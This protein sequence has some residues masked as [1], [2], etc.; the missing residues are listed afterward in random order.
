MKT[1]IYYFLNAEETKSYQ[2][3]SK[4]FVI[5]ICLGDLKNW[6]HFCGQRAHTV[7]IDKEF[8]TKT[9]QDIIK[10]VI[11]PLACLNGGEGICF[12]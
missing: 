7:Y 4:N 3:N 1:I 11:K 6:T 2:I 5:N 9:Y 12:I 10:E 8:N